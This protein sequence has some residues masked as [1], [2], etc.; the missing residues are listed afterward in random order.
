MVSIPDVHADAGYGIGDSAHLTGF[1]SVVAVPLM[2]DG[3]PI[4][5]INVGRVEPGPFSENHL[6]L[7]QTFADQ[8]VIA[9]E[10]VRLFKELEAR[11]DA[12]HAIGG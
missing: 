11:T 7:L 8:A 10:N 12:A 9:I 3:R 5:V 6:A 2:R 1:R 4:G